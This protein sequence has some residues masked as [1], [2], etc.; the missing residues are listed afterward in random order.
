MAKIFASFRKN[1]IIYVEGIFYLLLLG[2]NVFVG[3]NLYQNVILDV[4]PGIPA[5]GD[6]TPV[7][8]ASLNKSGLTIFEE[9][10]SDRKFF[11]IGVDTIYTKRWENFKNPTDPFLR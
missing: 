4:R 6:L 10:Q 3:Y 1:L 9:D 2:L 11:I 8:V 7:K 5:A